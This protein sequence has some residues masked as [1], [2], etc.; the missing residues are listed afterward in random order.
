[1]I[2]RLATGDW[3]TSRSS[4]AGLFA[5]AYQKS[6]TANREKLR[7]LFQGLCN[8]DTPMVRRAAASNLA[9]LIA[10]METDIVLEEAIPQ[11]QTLSEDDQDSVRLLTVEALIA[12]AK[13]LGSEEETRRRALP[14]LKTLYADKSWRVRYMV[15]DH[16][17]R[18][19]EA[20]GPSIVASDLVPA[21][22]Q[23][24]RDSEAEVRTAIAGQISGFCKLVPT[25]TILDSILPVVKDL[26]TDP[27]QYVRAAWGK[28]IS[29]L[30][31]IMGKEATIQH[32]LPM[33]LQMLKD[34]YPDVRLNII[35]QLEQVNQVIG[36]ELLSQSLL[37]AIVKLA[38]DKQWRIRLAIIEYIP[39]LAGQLGVDFFNKELSVLCMSWLGDSV[40]SIR[41][42]ATI[43]LRKLTEVFGIDW[44]RETIIPKVL[45]MGTHTN[46]L[47]R[48][49]TIFAIIT[50]AP[51]VNLEVVQGAIQPTLAQL[52]NDRIPNIRFNVA[53]A[54]EA[55]A[56][57][58][59]ETP[60]GR[61]LLQG[62][63]RGSLERLSAD[64]DSDV[65]Y[66]ANRAMLSV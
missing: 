6:D 56:P 36:I 24:L 28:Q 13:A 7:T 5:S 55:L 40:F 18:I 65:K 51:V 32:L 37:P 4:A 9:K 8:D 1:M 12:V 59:K 34:E 60:E 27:S 26:I 39:L 58:L 66:F 10:E 15:A 23:L 48:M 47:Y 53:K 33:F 50:L 25:E 17:I 42:A 19:A 29:S 38:E 57:V 30:A 31:P 41:E 35:S 63:I 64:A 61:E 16:F 49:T 22:L 14:I 20:C 52:V 2:E 45:T 54:F 43:N 44:A 21:F 46:Y 62:Q 11:L 3:F